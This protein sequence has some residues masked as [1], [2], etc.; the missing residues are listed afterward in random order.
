M[1]RGRSKSSGSKTTATAVKATAAQPK[2]QVVQP[3]QA[4]PAPPPAPQIV[5]PPTTADVKKGNVLPSGGVPFS[6]F[7]KMTDDQKADIVSTALD[8]GVPMFLEDSGM[9]RLAYFTGMSEKPTVVSDAALDKIKGEE[10]FRTINDA[11]NASIDIGY[12]SRDI[13]KQISHGDFTMYSDS[14]GSAHG[15]AI[16]FANNYRDSSYYGN[17]SKNPV[18]MRAKITGKTVTES[19]LRSMYSRAL[20]RGDKLALACQKAGNAGDARNMYGL[21][22]G[23]D[24]VTAANGYRMVLNRRGITVSDTVKPTIYGG[25]G[26]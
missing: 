10:M 8:T 24:V 19:R 13:A 7:E 6:Q 18:T 2:A 12:S 25:S 22:K 1:G 4:A 26:W 3:Q 17:S 23:Y 15:K 14:G 9:Q 16:Y 21:A 20:Q 11:Y 5:N